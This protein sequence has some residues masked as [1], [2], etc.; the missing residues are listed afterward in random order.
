MNPITLESLHNNEHFLRAV[1][2][3]GGHQDVIVGHPIQTQEG[4]TLMRRGAHVNGDFHSTLMGQHLGI[5]PD[6]NLLAEK[7]VDVPTLEAQVLYLA[8]AHPLG[9]KLTSAL[10]GAHHMIEPLRHMPWPHPAS[11]KMTVM[12]DQMPDLFEHSVLMMMVSLYLTIR[13]SMSQTDQVNVAAAALMHDIGMLYLPEHWANTSHRMSAQELRELTTHP[14]I[15]MLAVREMKVYSVEVER[16]IAEHHERLDGSGYPNR[17]Q[18]RQISPLGEVLM[19]AEVIS[20]MYAKFIDSPEHHLSLMLRI[21]HHRFDADLTRHAFSLMGT[22]VPPP[23]HVDYKPADMRHGVALISG[24]YQRW[25]QCKKALP[26]QWS[27]QAGAEICAFVDAKLGELERSLAEAGIHPHQQ[28]D[29]MDIL[30]NDPT[31]MSEVM[32]TLREAL[33]EI[34]TCAQGCINRWPFL[35]HPATTRIGQSVRDWL[36][37]VHATHQQRSRGL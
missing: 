31:A 30:E 4:T 14:T 13:R 34:D 5:S 3:M 35:L 32:L 1:G 28:A 25:A 7:V 33:R 24:I 20:A 26:P 27:T 9:R 8:A 12:R 22:D 37:A 36:D 29:W 15:G 16:A 18:D 11:F 21:N 6:N 19:L 2:R 23:G 10:K 17:L